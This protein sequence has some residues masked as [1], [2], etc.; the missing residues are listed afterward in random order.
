MLQQLFITRSQTHPTGCEHVDGPY[1]WHATTCKQ[2]DLFIS[3]EFNWNAL[4]TTA[5][6][7]A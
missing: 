2:F 1:R 6:S 5:D 4:I 7:T 3:I